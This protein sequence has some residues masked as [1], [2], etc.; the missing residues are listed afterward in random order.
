[1]ALSNQDQGIV[2]MQ[3]SSSRQP[4]YDENG[5]EIIFEGICW[6]TG[7][8]HAVKSSYTSWGRVSSAMCCMALYP[9]CIPIGNYCGNKA[10]KVWRLYLTSTHIRYAIRDGLNCQ[11]VVGSIAL[12]DVT[13]IQA[14]SGT[15]EVRRWCYYEG[16]IGTPTQIQIEMRVQ[17]CNICCC[18]MVSTSTVFELSYCKNA[19]EFVEAVKRQLNTMARE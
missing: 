6:N 13:N 14:K 2:T 16:K 18:H 4:K 5:D 1:M 7:L 10:C 11:S 15:V 19:T 17:A 12:T 9:L 8:K 3:Q